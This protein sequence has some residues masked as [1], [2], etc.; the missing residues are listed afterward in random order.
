MI[1]HWVKIK[2]FQV[3]KKKK[4]KKTTTTTCVYNTIGFTILIVNNLEFQQLNSE[5]IAFGATMVEIFIDNVMMVSMM[6]NLRLK[7]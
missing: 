6:T 7:Q 3:V 2:I 5:E 4:K 1:H